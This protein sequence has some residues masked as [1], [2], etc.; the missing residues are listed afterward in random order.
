[1]STFVPS[2]RFRRDYDKIFRK[3]PAAANVMLLLCELADEKGQVRLETPFPEVEIQR[4]MA[5]RFTDPRVYALP[6]GPRR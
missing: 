2:R 3:D 4:L 5:A 1:M 6:G